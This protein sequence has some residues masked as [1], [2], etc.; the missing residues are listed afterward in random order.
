MSYLFNPDK[1]NI[2][3]VNSR[4]FSTSHPHFKEYHGAL[5]SFLDIPE[6]KENLN[7][8]NWDNLIKIWVVHD[9]SL[10]FDVFAYL[11][12]NINIGVALSDNIYS[13]YSTLICPDNWKG[14]N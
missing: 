4:I 13:K 1:K 3:E 8:N 6:V 5:Q 9:Y 2:K 14:V 12:L 11:L 10:S 7:N